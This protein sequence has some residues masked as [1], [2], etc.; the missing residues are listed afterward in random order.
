MPQSGES[1]YPSPLVAWITVVALFLAYILSFIDRMIIGLLVEPLKADLGLSD[2]QISLLQGMAFAVFYTVAGIPLGRLIDRANRVRIVTIG[3]AA[4]SFFTMLCGFAGQYWQLFAARMGVGVGE[5]TL[6]PAAYSMISDTF[7]PRRLGLAMGVYGLGSAIGAGLAF[8]IGAAVVSLVAAAGE[9]VLPI[10]GEVRAWQAAFLLVGAPGIVFAL[11]FLFIPEPARRGDAGLARVAV[12]FAEV[13]AHSRREARTLG[14]IFFGVG[15]VNLAVFAAV[16]WLPVLYMR[17]HGLGIGEAG[18]TAGAAMV[19]GG[20]VGMVGG[21]WA[22][23]RLGGRPLDRMRFATVTAFIGIGAA[24]AF[25]LMSGVTGTT[26]V[27]LLFFIACTAPTGA[28]IAALQQVVPGRMRATLSAAYIFVVNFVGMAFG[29]TLTALIGDNF[30]PE[31]DGIRYAV[32]IVAGFGFV[33]A[34]L[35]FAATAH[36]LRHATAA[37]GVGRGA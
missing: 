17:V 26:L 25:P 18:Y 11:V 27:F 13:I 14:G 4:W 5:A 8:M 23:D 33:A 30:F 37:G 35:L 6:S 34:T 22:C 20:L 21:G 3:I 28:A 2:T 15:F 9:V 36:G 32:A 16:S 24:F 19:I 1:P 12:P 10:V 29:P 31:R 7:P